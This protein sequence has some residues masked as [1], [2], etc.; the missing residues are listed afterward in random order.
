MHL[1]F[2]MNSLALIETNTWPFCGKTSERVG[3]WV[4]DE[5]RLTLS[6]RAYLPHS[7]NFTMCVNH[8]QWFHD[9]NPFPAKSSRALLT[10]TG[11]ISSISVRSSSLFLRES[12]VFTIM[13]KWHKIS[14]VR[15][16]NEHI[17]SRTELFLQWT[18][19]SPIWRN[20]R[21]WRESMAK[22]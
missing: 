21:L 5:L 10:G 2:I 3:I 12:H 14:H 15:G 8:M 9:V 19:H 17:G 22:S 1:A 16:H 18:K 7:S 4:Y 11:K 6:H 13:M 20:C